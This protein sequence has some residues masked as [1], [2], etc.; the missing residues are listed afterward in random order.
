M[1]KSILII[2]D[3]PLNCEDYIAPLRERYNVTT[4]MS[5]L[6]ADRKIWLHQYDVI[7]IDIMMPTLGVSTKDELKTGLFFYMEQ[8]KPKSSMTTRYLFWSS[9]SKDTFD[10]FF[11][12]EKP[13]NVDFVHKEPKNINH[14]LNKVIELIG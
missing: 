7:V 11:Q 14:L 8:L 2:D 6:D 1:K 13:N 10:D 3:N 9:L 4:C 12:E 5:L